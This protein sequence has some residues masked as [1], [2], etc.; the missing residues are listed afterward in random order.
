MGEMNVKIAVRLIFLSVIVVTSSLWA[1]STGNLDRLA[2]W[3]I[4]SFSSAEQAALDAEY[5]DIRLEVVRIWPKRD[6]G[7][8]LYVEQ[9][10]AAALDKPY[11]LRI[12]HLRALDAGYIESSV[13]TIKNDSVLAGAWRSPDIFLDLPLDSLDLRDGCSIVLRPFADYAF[14]GNTIGRVCESSLRGAAYALSEVEIYAD[15]MISWDRGF[16]AAGKQVWGATRGGYIF[17][18]I[19][20]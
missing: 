9:A 6:D 19:K 13:Y 1:E 4:G 5:Y 7:Y 14:V 2:G 11:R 10:T 20:R 16:D 17:T 18:K 3:M 15:R 8:W 12:Y